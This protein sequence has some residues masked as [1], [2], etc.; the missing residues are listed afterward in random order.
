MKTIIKA[1]TICF[2]ALASLNSYA[3]E[4]FSTYTNS[5]NGK[6]Y[7]IKILSKRKNDVNIWIDAM[8]FDKL[9]YQGGLKINTKSYHNLMYAIAK[10][11]LKY[12]E[13][14]K[15]AK[16]NNV[17]ELTKTMKYR[18]KVDTYF[19]YGDW[20]YDRNVNLYFEFKIQDKM[21]E[22]NYL[23]FIKTGELQ[24]SRNRLM[25]VDGLAL[26]FSSPAEIEK[27]TNTISIASVNS[28]LNRPNANKL[29]KD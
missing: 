1:I 13:W 9:H 25:K 11:K 20:N 27:F 4:D 2:F 10:A 5:Y 18:C 6:T 3:Q 14:I 16:E 28:F 12:E 19:K 22:I 23:L 26:V 15:T 17:K 8:S 7:N 29:F 24:S 21:G